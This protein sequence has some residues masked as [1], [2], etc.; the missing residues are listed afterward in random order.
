MFDHIVPCGIAD[1]AVTSLAAE[2]IDGD[3]GRGRRRRQPRGAASVGGPRVSSA[4]TSPGARLRRTS[5]RSAGASGA[6]S[7]CGSRAVSPRRVSPTACTSRRASPSG[8]E[9][10][11]ARSRSR[12]AA[13][14]DA[15][16]RPR[17]RVRGGGLP[18]HLRVLVRRHRHVHDQ[19]RARARGRAA[20]AS[21]TPAG[22]CHSTPTSPSGWP[23]RSPAWAWRTPW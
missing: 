14:H 5:H 16:P 10:R 15:R 6:A 20:S 13:A 19:R 11:E 4:K 22:R 18:E 9:R 17:H 7:R 8:C 12:R 3:D 2:G 1:K 21:S 23:R